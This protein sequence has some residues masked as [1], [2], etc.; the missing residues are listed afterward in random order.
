MTSRQKAAIIVRMALAQG[1]EIKL[2]SLPEKLQT[3]LVQQMSGLTRVD[4]ATVD[5]VVDE[6]A[7]SFDTAGLSFP[8]ALRE[9][10][11][12]MQP[13]IS[14]ELVLRLR[15]QA[16]LSVHADPWARLG[17]LDGDT[18]L[19]VLEGESIEVAAVVL[20][21]LKVSKAAELLSKMPGE[22]A[23]RIA[24][25]ISLTGSIP[26]KVVERIGHTIAEQFDAAPELAFADGPVE[27][28]G[29]IL[30]FS[31][32]SRRD[33]VLEG[34]EKDDHGFAAEVR[35]AIFTFANIPDRIDPRDVPKILREVD[36]DQLIVALAGVSGAT[37]KSR[38]F[39]FE[40]MSKR[41]GEQLRDEI[42]DKGE[43]KPAEAEA[44]M[45]SVVVSIREMEAAGEIFLT[46]A[47]EEEEEEAKE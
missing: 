32:A 25:A 6:F 34:L 31:T 47:E 3:E 24:Y 2:S 19:P 40:N 33:E 21:K 22:R 18:L 28:V 35:K 14:A 9:T 10:L 1:V 37:E 29:A 27:K 39:I 44:A 26:P 7:A 16:G 12:L 23:R 8:G 43:V 38:D 11:D 42:N 45:T 46:A 41:M 20:S 5:A 36:Q 30:N 4:K 15:K 17:E 13:T